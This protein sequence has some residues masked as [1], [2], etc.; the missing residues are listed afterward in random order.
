MSAIRRASLLA[1]LVLSATLTLAVGC[2]SVG[3]ESANVRA[4][5]LHAYE[6]SYG[7]CRLPNGRFANDECCE[8]QAELSD[9]CV[10][11]SDT[12]DLDHSATFDAIEHYDL[13]PD[14][15]LT[16]EQE[17]QVLASVKYLDEGA[18]PSEAIASTDDG[19]I[20]VTVLVDRFDG[21]R[22]THFRHYGGDNEVGTI[23]YG[24][25]AE[26]AAEVGDGDFWPCNA[27]EPVGRWDGMTSTA[28]D[29]PAEIASLPGMMGVAKFEGLQAGDRLP[30]SAR[31]VVLDQVHELFGNECHGVPAGDEISWWTPEELYHW[32][33]IARNWRGD[34]E[35]H[36]KGAE[37]DAMEDYYLDHG[38]TDFD[39]WSEEF[40]GEACAGSGNGE[41]V[42]LHNRMS[43]EVHYYVFYEYTE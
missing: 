19:E 16:P 23:F 20:N 21:T 2:N 30:A 17:A 40:S 7:F 24:D 5:C 4:E 32:V 18:S 41:I 27:K 38:D 11:G 29:T 43:H 12:H 33:L 8:P 39:M 28:T 25:T 26:V 13:L 22:Y 31:G 34:W 3:S 37:L 14:S 35:T 9:H 10:F 6:D 15:E 42:L 1:G 36:P